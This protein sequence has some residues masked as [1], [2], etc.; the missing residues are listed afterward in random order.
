MCTFMQADKEGAH[1]RGFTVIFII[2][3]IA[4]FHYNY[5]ISPYRANS[6]KIHGVHY[7]CGAVVRMK[8][9]QSET[10]P[11]QYGKLKDFYIYKDHKIITAQKL[12]VIISNRHIRGIQVDLI[13]CTAVS[14]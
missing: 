11:F 1:K 5:I 2:M 13:G 9:D 6:L 8:S 7:K 4:G 12:N 3:Y 14:F 10:V